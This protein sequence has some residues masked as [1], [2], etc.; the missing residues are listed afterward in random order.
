MFD[1]IL[2]LINLLIIITNLRWAGG[3]LNEMMT[4]TNQRLILTLHPF[5]TTTSISLSNKSAAQT[6]QTTKRYSFALKKHILKR[7]TPMALIKIVL[8]RESSESRNNSNRLKCSLSNFCRLHSIKAKKR[9]RQWMN[10]PSYLTQW[11]SLMN[12]STLTNKYQKGL[13]L[14]DSP[15]KRLKNLNQKRLKTAGKSMICEINDIFLL[16]DRWYAAT[17]INYYGRIA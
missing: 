13:Q 1:M 2:Q 15:S 17:I 3:S 5:P 7:R 14:Q 11:N 6:I 4:M 12:F 10:S 9:R 16:I 8:R